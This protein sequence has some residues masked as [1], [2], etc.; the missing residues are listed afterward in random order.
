MTDL[1]HA[2]KQ[3]IPVQSH[4]VCQMPSEP[5]NDEDLFAV[6]PKLP[7]GLLTII[8]ERII[9]V[10]EEKKL[11]INNLCINCHI[12]FL[13]TTEALHTQSLYRLHFHIINILTH[14]FM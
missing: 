3:K 7:Y 13:K 5:S 9:Y 1:G 11:K 14:A 8:F 12:L 4:H 10:K 6:S 2:K